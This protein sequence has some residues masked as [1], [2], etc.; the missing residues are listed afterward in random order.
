MG[1]FQ[2]GRAPPIAGLVRKVA[3]SIT[4]FAASEAVPVEA[5]SALIGF[6]GVP[7]PFIGKLLA[8]RYGLPRRD[9]PAA[10]VEK[11]C[12]ALK[13]LVP[14]L[15]ASD[16]HAAIGRRFCDDAPTKTIIDANSD[17]ADQVM[18]PSDK[19]EMKTVNEDAGEKRA[20]HK[21]V[22]AAAHKSA[23][24]YLE[25]LGIKK[26][27]PAVHVVGKLPAFKKRINWKNVAEVVADRKLIP[28]VK[29]CRLQ[30]IKSRSKRIAFYPGVS[31]ASRSRQY[32]GV[33]TEAVVVRHCIRWLWAMHKKM[34]GELC[35]FE[36]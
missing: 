1:S 14:G 23:D 16:V 36:L 30:P 28:V 26:P 18:D 12:V 11:I 34:T 6:V 35:P 22:L 20:A 27:T 13:M 21:E 7:S 25:V 4:L 10:L 15:K 2:V 9:Q 3:P 31:P 32:G 5:A 17:L 33:I 29:E 19:K 8:E 24:R